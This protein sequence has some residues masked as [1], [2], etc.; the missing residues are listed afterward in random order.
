MHIEW[1]ITIGTLI[2]TAVIV[3]AIIFGWSALVNRLAILE[4]DLKEHKEDLMSH[5]ERMDIYENDLR[6]LVGSMQKM[7]GEFGMYIRMDIESRKKTS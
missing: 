7:I 1:T 5:G 6:T 2:Q 4:K 3:I